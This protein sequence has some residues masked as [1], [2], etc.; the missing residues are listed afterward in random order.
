VP[1]TGDVTS[2][3]DAAATGA[4]AGDAVRLAV[5]TFTLL[6]VRPPARVDRATVSAALVVVP[7][8]AAAIGG[9]AGAVLELTRVL[10]HHSL[11]G[12]LLAAVLAV[13]TLVLLSRA[14]HLDG[15]ADTADGLAASGTAVG[16]DREVARTRGLDAMKRSDIGPYGVVAVVLVLLVQATAAA[17]SIGRGTGWLGLLGAAVAGRTAVVVA[18]VRGTPAARPDGLGAA[19]AQ[20]V[21]PARAWV[22]VLVVAALMAAVAWADDDRGWALSARAAV[23]VLVAAAAAWIVVWRCRSR[24]GGVTG[25]V[26]GAVVEVGTMVALLT[27]ALG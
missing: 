2:G 25:D 5:G 17:E 12:R 16:A 27:Y 10:T 26:M 20:A 22:Q 7:V 8:V 18:C 1:S 11:A 4:A 6:P 24:L 9:A 23:A 21:R 3:P 15:L 13:C 14:V 19:W